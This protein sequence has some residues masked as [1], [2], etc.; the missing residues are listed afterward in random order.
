MDVAVEEMPVPGLEEAFRFHMEF[1]LS[2]EVGR[3]ATGG[4]RSI[5]PLVAGRVEGERLQARL[6]SGSETHLSRL[7]GVTTIEAVYV[8]QAE[9]GSVIRILGTGCRAERSGFDG[10]RMTIVFEVDEGAA[11][12]WLATRAFVAE[13]ATGADTLTI[14]QII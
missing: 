11:H 6:L 9:D 3:L 12:A 4:R 5:L 2:A 10:V 7:D 13:R 1:G 14:A 8:V